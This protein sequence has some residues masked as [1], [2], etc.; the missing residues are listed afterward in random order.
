MPEDIVMEKGAGNMNED[1][2]FDVEEARIMVEDRIQMEVQSH[3]AKENIPS[4]TLNTDAQT[5][6]PHQPVAHMAQ[7]N[8]DPRGASISPNNHNT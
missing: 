3:A 8:T 5:N 2:N 4:I 6:G 7:R 1:P